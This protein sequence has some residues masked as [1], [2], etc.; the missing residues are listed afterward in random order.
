[1]QVMDI[2]NRAAMQSG[3]VPSFNPDEVPEDIQQRGADILRHELIPSINCDRALDITEVVHRA[4][5]SRGVVD[6]ATTPLNYPREIYGTVP[7]TSSELMQVSTLTYMGTDVE[8]RRNLAQLLY[9]M[10][11]ITD[12]TGSPT[13]FNLPL[14]DKWPCDQ[15]GNPRDIAIWSEDHKLIEVEHENQLAAASSWINTTYNVPFAPMR[16]DE[17]YRASDGAPLAYVHAGEFV[18]NE[19]R[20]AQLVFTV[21]DYPE[22]MRIR[23]P[24]NFGAGEALIILPVPIKIVNSYEEPNPWQGTI[25]APEKFRGYLIAKLS[26]RLAVEYGIATA[27]AMKQLAAEAY[28]YLLKN[29][30]K[31]EHPQDISRKMFSYLQRGRGWRAGANGN[32]YVGGFNG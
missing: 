9:N 30:S 14:S 6:L 29:P 12:L 8:V 17:V 28:Q 3:A 7:L 19:F 1:M 15:F 13:P 2:V 31:H 4:V 10:G 22:K 20:Y 32:G 5:P 27:D 11:L 25:V 26:Y 21:E 16:V 18:S 24:Q 23:F